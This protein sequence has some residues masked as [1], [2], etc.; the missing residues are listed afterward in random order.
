[1]PKYEILF[2][3]GKGDLFS[4]IGVDEDC[5]SAALVELISTMHRWSPPQE[6]I[7]VYK[8]GDL[9]PGLEPGETVK[10]Q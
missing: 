7:A 2:K 10:P 9:V 5:L 8:D 6:I 4:Q 3:Y 1:M